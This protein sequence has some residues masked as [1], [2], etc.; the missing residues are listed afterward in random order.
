[1]AQQLSQL[2]FRVVSIRFEKTRGINMRLAEIAFQAERL[3]LGSREVGK[4]NMP[5]C[6]VGLTLLSFMLM[7]TLLIL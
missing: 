3:H 2:L 1:M 5:Q 7:K 6:S 4:I